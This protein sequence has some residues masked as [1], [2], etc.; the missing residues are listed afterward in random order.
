MG[1]ERE[2]C[3]ITL[4]LEEGDAWSKRL[5]KQREATSRSPLSNTS[6]VSLLP[7]RNLVLPLSPSS[8]PGEQKSKKSK[9]GTA[10]GGGASVDGASTGTAAGGVKA[11]KGKSSGSKTGGKNTVGGKKTATATTKKKEGSGSSR[12]V[13]PRKRNWVCRHGSGAVLFGRVDVSRVCDGDVMCCP[14]SYFTLG[15]D[16]FVP[17][18]FFRC[19]LG[20]PPAK[21]LSMLQNRLLCVQYIGSSV[22]WCTS[23]CGFLQ[24]SQ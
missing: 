21:T 9:H 11:A 10:A 7:P 16:F 5:G 6:F 20:R 4:C 14:A 15:W 22:S 3:S 17:P 8:R 2:R 19:S 24:P 12:C 23:C 13:C 1:R 18:P